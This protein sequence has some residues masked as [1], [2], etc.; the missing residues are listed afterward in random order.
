MSSPNRQK[1]VYA[2]KAATTTS[3]LQYTELERLQLMF[4]HVLTGKKQETLK[5][6][7]VFSVSLYII[8]FKFEFHV[9]Y[10]VG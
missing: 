6:Q 1:R 5:K 8:Y 10:H 9:A 4:C 3:D 7:P 2:T